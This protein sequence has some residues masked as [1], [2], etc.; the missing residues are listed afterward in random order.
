VGS[1]PNGR[2]AKIII[3][4][5]ISFF[6]KCYQNVDKYFDQVVLDKAMALCLNKLCGTQIHT[7]H[8]LHLVEQGQPSMMCNDYIWLEKKKFEQQTDDIFLFQK[9]NCLDSKIKILNNKKQ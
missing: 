7:P 6:Y 3:A 2:F 4:Y 5:L 1:I 9:L 8:I